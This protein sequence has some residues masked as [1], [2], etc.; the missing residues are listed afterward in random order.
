LTRCLQEEG[1]GGHAS[2]ARSDSDLARQLQEEWNAADAPPSLD[3][4]WNATPTRKLTRHR[5]D[6][7]QL[8]FVQVVHV[9]YKLTTPTSVQ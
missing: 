7:Y 2:R 4:D 1:R 3:P 6:R 9:K 5:T 8:L